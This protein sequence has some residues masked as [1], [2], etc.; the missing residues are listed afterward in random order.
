MKARWAPPA[1]WMPETLEQQ[2]VGG[3]A[4]WQCERLRVDVEGEIA[5]PAVSVAR[6]LTHSGVARSLTHSGVAGTA[7]KPVS[8]GAIDAAVTFKD[9][10]QFNSQVP[11]RNASLPPCAA[12]RLVLLNLS[13]SVEHTR[14]CA[15]HVCADRSEATVRA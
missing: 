1:L 12:R 15:G 10:T 3:S 5:G 4:D 9:F 8:T 11:T 13:G 7:D 6:S 2:C 14:V